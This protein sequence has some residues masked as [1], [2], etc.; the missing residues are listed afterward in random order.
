M[1]WG[2]RKEGH[3]QMS[4]RT[5]RAGHQGQ[6]DA[7]AR[8][9]AVILLMGVC[10]VAAV[11]GHHTHLTQTTSSINTPLPR[12]ITHAGASPQT[13]PYATAAMLLTLQSKHAQ[14]LAGLHRLPHGNLLVI[15]H[16]PP[17][18]AQAAHRQ[19][20]RRVQP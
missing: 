14:E 7:T 8:G 18:R 20:V 6:K 15:M 17:R 2:V 4:R 16:S 19:P 3:D 11:L 9:P 1:G 13:Q 5:Q 12:P 10:G